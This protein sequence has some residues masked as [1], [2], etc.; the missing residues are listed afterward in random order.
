MVPPMSCVYIHLYMKTSLK[1]CVC[2]VCL[3][4]YTYITVRLLEQISH[5][6]CIFYWN[7]ACTLLNILYY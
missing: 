4:K 6:Y 3:L 7:Y 2:S 5:S 1:K